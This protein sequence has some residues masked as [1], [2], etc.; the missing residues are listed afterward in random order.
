MKNGPEN[1]LV[2]QLAAELEKA[3]RKNKKAVWKKAATLIRRP[4]RKKQA[5]NLYKLD[6]NSKEDETLLVPTK[7]LSEGN[8]T[9]AFSVAALDI[10][11]TARQKLEKNGCKVK[12]IKQLLEENPSGKNVKIII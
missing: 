5:V 4:S 8:T 11:K 2:I 12:T 1:P 10:S 9:H 6:K 7:I 3:S